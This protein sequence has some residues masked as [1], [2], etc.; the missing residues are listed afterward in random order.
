[1]KTKKYFTLIELLVV[2]AIIAILA[3]MLLPA[4]GQAR[5]KA[6]AINCMNNLKQIGTATAFYA[7]NHDGYILPIGVGDAKYGTID[8]TRL[9]SPLLGL[10][11]I[12][13]WSAGSSHHKF[14]Y[15]DSNHQL[16]WPTLT[17]IFWSNYA[18]NED[19]MGYMYGTNN[20]VEIRLRKQSKLKQTSGTFLLTDGKGA[21]LKATLESHITGAD[22]TNCVIWPAHQGLK[23]FNALFVDGHAKNYTMADTPNCFAHNGNEL[24][25]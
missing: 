22:V 18:T 23:R 3:S 9:I 7:D 16:K 4:L 24:F 8:W 15:C 17:N 14:F 21:P 6:K 13:P 25:K 12:S 1:M 2:I 11:Q 20:T 19:V 10:E 5:E